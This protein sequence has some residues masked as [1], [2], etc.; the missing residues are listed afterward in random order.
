VKGVK[1]KKGVE[2]L[3]YSAR[4]VHQPL[5]TCAVCRMNI[6]SP[7]SP[8]CKIKSTTTTATTPPPP[9]PLRGWR[10][11]KKKKKTATTTWKWKREEGGGGKGKILV[12]YVI[13]CKF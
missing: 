13:T 11:E 12:G 6:F 7:F 1:E 9:P 2:A 5:N 4:R 8:P 3:L 10:T